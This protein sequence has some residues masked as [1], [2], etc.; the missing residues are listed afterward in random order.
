MEG[1]IGW[2]MDDIPLVFVLVHGNNG[3][4][5]DWLHIVEGIQ[6]HGGLGGGGDGGDGRRECHTFCFS[7]H[8]GNKTL[9]GV[10]GLAVALEEELNQYLC[11]SKTLSMAGRI[12]VYFIGHSLG[13]LVI[14]AA[15][16]SILQRMQQLIPWGYCSIATPHLGV[17]RP[18]GSWVKWLWKNAVENTCKNFYAQTGS[19]L[20]YHSVHTHQHSLEE[21]LLYRLA[22]PQGP[23]MQALA[24]F[25]HRTLVSA[26]FYDMLVPY[27]TASMRSWHPYSED[28]LEELEGDTKCSVWGYSRSFSP[29]HEKV[30]AR[31]ARATA[32]GRPDEE[33]PADEAAVIDL[34]EGWQADRHRFSKWPVRVMG[35]VSQMPF[36]RLDVHLQC[37]SRWQVHDGFLKKVFLFSALWLCS[38][39]LCRNSAISSPMLAQQ[40]ISLLNCWLRSLRWTPRLIGYKR[41]VYRVSSLAS[42]RQHENNDKSHA[43]RRLGRPGLATA[44]ATDMAMRFSRPSSNE[45]EAGWLA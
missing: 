37:A 9:I 28:E 14:R 24:K 12:R 42:G 41:R 39:G 19:D 22:D 16:P 7:T 40:G 43:F 31:F 20:V 26:P 15:L 11:N 32:A 29:E 30:I 44:S 3:D 38:L 1:L 45:N 6:H 4:A 34:E 27:C 18:G 33:P 8:S 21:T 35:N 25:E 5:G 17:A 13:G 2:G 36:R 23:Y 10:E